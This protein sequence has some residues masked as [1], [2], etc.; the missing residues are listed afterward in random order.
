LGPQAREARAAVSVRGG[1]ARVAPTYLSPPSP[2]PRRASLRGLVS[3]DEKSLGSLGLA[4]RVFSREE[5][6]PT[7]RP[8]SWSASNA[9]A[10]VSTSGVVVA[11]AAAEDPSRGSETAA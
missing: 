11:V 8:F 4:R 6:L 7:P 10:R 5:K 9:A 2:S 3:R 1:R